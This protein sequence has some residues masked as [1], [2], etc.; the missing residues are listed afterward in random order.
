MREVV[1]LEDSTFQEAAFCHVFETC[2]ITFS[3]L[4]AQQLF[5]LDWIQAAEGAIGFSTIGN[6]KFTQGFV[7]C[8]VGRLE[9]G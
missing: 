7:F 5:W 8:K 1:L 4:A 3:I 6:L 2:C 9:H